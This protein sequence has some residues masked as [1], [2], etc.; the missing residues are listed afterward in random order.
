[1]ITLIGQLLEVLDRNATWVEWSYTLVGILA[2][3]ITFMVY[4]EERRDLKYQREQAR[5]SPGS[6]DGELL[7][8]GS[9]VHG[10]EFL[11][12]I[13]VTVLVLGGSALVTAPAN[14][15]TPVTTLGII[16]AVGLILINVLCAIKALVTFVADKQLTVIARRDVA[17]RWNGEE[18]RRRNTPCPHCGHIEG[19]GH[20]W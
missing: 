14:P 18:R 3:I 1:M 10:R 2:L 8:A 12:G 4:R 20:E 16:F 9:T 5:K 19:H 13:E 7:V 6:N 17:L 11:I 15:Q